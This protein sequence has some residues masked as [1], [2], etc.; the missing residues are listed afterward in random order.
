[1]FRTIL[2]SNDE[3][4][5]RELQGQIHSAAEGAAGFGQENG[6]MVSP[7]IKNDD[8]SSYFHVSV[9]PTGTDD[10]TIDTDVNALDITYGDEEPEDSTDGE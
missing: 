1:M 6:V 7:L 2:R 3:A 9:G 4:E 10:V 8:E 5:L